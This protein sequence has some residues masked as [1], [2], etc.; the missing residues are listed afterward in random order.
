MKIYNSKFLTKNDALYKLNE[1]TVLN[2]GKKNNREELL[3]PENNYL[4][5]VKLKKLLQPLKSPPVVCQCR[6]SFC[7]FLCF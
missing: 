3:K 6:I 2:H 1:G 7:I 4:D 5:I